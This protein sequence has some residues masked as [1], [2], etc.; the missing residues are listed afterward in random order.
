MHKLE[1]RRTSRMCPPERGYVDPERKDFNQLG[2]VNKLGFFVVLEEEEIPNNVLI[3]I[4][5][6]GSNT[7]DWR[8]KFINWIPKEHGGR[9]EEF[10]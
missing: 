2:Y 8:S 1:V 10:A 9:A 4:G 5:A 7:S 3:E 6:L